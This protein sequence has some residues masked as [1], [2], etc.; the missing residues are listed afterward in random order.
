MQS[1][2]LILLS[3]YGISFFTVYRALRGCGALTVL[4]QGGVGPPRQKLRNLLS[5]VNPAPCLGR[6]EGCDWSSKRSGVPRW[7]GDALHVERRR[8]AMLPLFL[9]TEKSFHSKFYKSAP[10]AIVT[11]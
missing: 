1:V 7:R 5:S 8:F 11:F 10:C 3:K 4:M 6:R 9:N 2:A